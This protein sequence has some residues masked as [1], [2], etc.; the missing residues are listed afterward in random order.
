M[1]GQVVSV[2]IILT[3]GSVQAFDIRE[4]DWDTFIHGGLVGEE[5]GLVLEMQSQSR[6]QKNKVS[7]R[8]QEGDPGT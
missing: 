4:H 1:P 7:V 6:E 5:K 8:H 3:Q 2:S